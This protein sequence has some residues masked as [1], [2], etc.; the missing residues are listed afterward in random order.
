MGCSIAYAVGGEG[1]PLVMAATW[2]TR[3]RTHASFKQNRTRAL[4][5]SEIMEGKHACINEPFD[6]GRFDRGI[7]CRRHPFVGALQRHHRLGRKAPPR[8]PPSSPL[9]ASPLHG[10]VS[11]RHI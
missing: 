11:P 7:A 9:P 3:A 10:H 8:F 1:P 6:S 4:R 5:V 2:R